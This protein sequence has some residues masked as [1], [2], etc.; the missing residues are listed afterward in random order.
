MDGAR[1]RVAREHLEVERTVGAADELRAPSFEIAHHLDN[2]VY[3]DTRELRIDQFA[4]VFEDVLEMELGAVVLAYRGCE[5]A[6]RDRR[7][8][9]GSAPLGHL[10]HR[11]ARFRALKRGHGARR[12][13][14]HNEHIGVVTDHRNVEAMCV[15]G[16]HF[17]AI[18]T[19][20]STQ[21]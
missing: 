4:A 16:N 3:P 18:S 5:T 9:A 8:A 19:N 11:N 10:D 17:L 7:T 14:A 15:A 12:A 1:A 20:A 13:P 2:V 6:A 21:A